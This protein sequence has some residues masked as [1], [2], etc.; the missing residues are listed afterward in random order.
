MSLQTANERETKCSTYLSTRYL[1]KFGN[2]PVS[3]NIAHTEIILS[4]LNKKLSFA[5]KPCFVFS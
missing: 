2:V 3:M 5:I 1:H 4:T